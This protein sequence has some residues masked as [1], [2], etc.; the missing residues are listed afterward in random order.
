MSCAYNERRH[1]CLPVML[2]Q[3]LV[4]VKFHDVNALKCH[5]ATL[6]GILS[7]SVVRKK[8]AHRKRFEFE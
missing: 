8:H 1:N 2:T 5:R 4:A 6:P 3:I 7:K